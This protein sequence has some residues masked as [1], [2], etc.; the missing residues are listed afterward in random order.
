MDGEPLIIVDGYNL[1]HQIVA[2]RIAGGPG[3]LERAR[4]VAIQR[5]RQLVPDRIHPLTTIVFDANSGLAPDGLEGGN[6]KFG[7]IRIVFATEYPDA[8][9]MIEEM[10]RRHSTPARLTAGK[11]IRSRDSIAPVPQPTSR[12]SPS[13]CCS[14]ALVASVVA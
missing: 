1:M 6:S 5:I 11:S 4:A 10:I 12:T 14:L 9:S 8:D 7:Q 3:G 2:P 13:A